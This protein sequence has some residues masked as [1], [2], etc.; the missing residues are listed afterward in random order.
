MRST[1]VRPVAARLHVRPVRTR[2]PL[3]FGR[4]VLTSVDL[5]HVEV[6]VE[7]RDGRRAR[8]VGETPLNVEWAWPSDLPHAVRR[9]AMIDLS[10]ALTRAWG[11]YDGTG[12]PL[13]VGHDFQRDVLPSV[14]TPGVPRLAALVCLS[15]FDLA[16]HDAYGRLHGIDIYDTYTADWLTRDLATLFG[17]TADAD[18][19]RGVFPSAFLVPP[20]RAPRQL[21][22]WH[23]V[24]GLDP[25][26][27]ADLTGEEPDDGYPVTLEEWIERDGLRRLKIK[28]SGIDP[29]ADVRRIA[30]VGE[31]ALPAGV[32]HLS[33]DFNGT[34]RDPAAV[35]AVL[36]ALGRDYADVR[37]LLRYVEQPFPYDLEA[38]PH[39]VHALSAVIP[40]FLDESAHDWT[41]VRLGRA[42]GWNGVALKTCKT[43]TGAILSLAWA[44]A[45]GMQLMVQD[46]TNPMLAMI[47]HV[48]LAAHAETSWG[49]E[50]NAMQFYPEA[51]VEEARV[52][53]GLY[54]RRDGHLDLGTIQGPGFGYRVEE[55]AR[56]WLN[57]IAE[58]GG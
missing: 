17:A 56:T 37:R 26:T 38:H 9:A 51:S 55:I 12:H 15:A 31:V 45:H 30:A 32:E 21:P 1:D 44:K 13:E 24:G 48:R 8:G 36:N 52:H 40:L 57:P 28:V 34:A 4:H 7:G 6:D 27:A 43:Q 49:V 54:Q 14:V 58:A 23:L 25:L 39:D 42:L 5:V 47:P 11:A 18:R 16:L 50:A 35:L 20:A 46:L 29:A 2:A 10:V 41:L 33:V 22:V 3:Q 19:F 53:P